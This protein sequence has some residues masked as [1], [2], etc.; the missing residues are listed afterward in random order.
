MMPYG[1]QVR[2]ALIRVLEQ[3]VEKIVEQ[4]NATSDTV[5]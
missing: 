4:V 5:I 2:L 1:L 3:Y